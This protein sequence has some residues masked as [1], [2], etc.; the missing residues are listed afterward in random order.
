MSE[1]YQRFNSQVLFGGRLEGNKLARFIYMDEAGTAQHEPVTIVTAVIVDPDTQLFEAERV[2]REANEAVP[3]EF[4]QDGWVFHATDVFSN[5]LKYD[6]R[7]SLTQR[8]DYMCQMMA[9]PRRLRLPIAFAK[10]RRTPESEPTPGP[11]N[12]P[13]FRYDHFEAFGY[14]AA[15]ADEYIRR[16]GH[17]NE[18]GALIAEDV[19]DVRRQLR[20]AVDHLR[21]QPLTIPPSDLEWTAQDT[22]RG[23]TD[24][25]GELRVTRIRKSILFVP[26]DEDPLTQLA[27]AVAFGLRRFIA[28]KSFGPRFAEAIYGQSD[29]PP[30]ENFKSRI[31]A[32][33]LTPRQA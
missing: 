1:P 19:Q 24:Q 33:Y 5:S 12:L 30:V 22:E 4:R 21:N 2:I 27:D 17:P 25:T 15:K 13:N 11:Y 7:W 23:Y 10:V 9:L 6:A 29:V 18:V 28:G 14:C 3:A 31:S 26:K 20:E 16:N 8:V 32:N